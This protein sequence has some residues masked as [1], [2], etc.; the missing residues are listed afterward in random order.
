KTLLIVGVVL[1]GRPPGGG[2]P[3]LRLGLPPADGGRQPHKTPLPI[4]KL[5]A[6]NRYKLIEE[7]L[8]VLLRYG[9]RTAQDVKGIAYLC[10]RCEELT[11]L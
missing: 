2:A 5:F 10:R 4:Q 1:G 3:R 6:P 11:L 8:E 7:A 9:G